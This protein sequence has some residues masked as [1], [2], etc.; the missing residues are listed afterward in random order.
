MVLTEFGYLLLFLGGV[1]VCLFCW[2]S[3]AS[4]SQ[5]RDTRQ[6]ADTARLTANK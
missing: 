5:P 1:A 6:S 4:F 2:L 3:Y